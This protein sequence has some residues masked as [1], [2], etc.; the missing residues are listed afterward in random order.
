MLKPESLPRGRLLSC[1]FSSGLQAHEQNSDR[2][3]RGVLDGGV[4]V[5]VPCTL[6]LVLIVS[7]RRCLPF[8]TSARSVLV[9]TTKVEC[10]LVLGA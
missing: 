6:V 9:Y 4:W 7:V 2:A 3:T 10:S 8:Q 1:H 5:F